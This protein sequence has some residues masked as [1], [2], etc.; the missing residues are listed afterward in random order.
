[1]N[2]KYVTSEMGFEG[3][4][5]KEYPHMRVFETQI[6]FLDA[7][8]IPLSNILQSNKVYSGDL[9]WNIG[10]GGFDKPYISFV[11][12]NFH[13]TVD[14]LKERFD[15]VYI[16]QDGE[17]GWWNQVDMKLQVWW[18]N[19]LNTADK[20][21]VP[22]ET[23]VNFYR[24]LFPN[25]RLGV[26]RSVM[27]DEGLDKS[28]FLNKEDRAILVGPCTYEYNGFPQVLLAQK[29]A[30][31]IDIP[32]MG[33]DRMPDDSWDMASNIGVNYLKH[34]TW[35]DWMYNLSRYSYGFMLM[36]ATAAG[37]FALNCA[38]HGIPCIGDKK[39][40]TQRILFPDL[41]V[42]TYEIG[43]ASILLDKLRTDK[44]FYIDIAQK[45][46]EIYNSEF[47]KEKYL[48]ILEKDF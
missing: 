21:F 41:S 4:F 22:N 30:M 1:M 34:M 39:A 6:Y 24:G 17:I 43:T 25:T 2:I 18:Y 8:H 38:Y 31:P 32:P 20:I 7:Q 15:N 36:N 33:E 19:Q 27:T 9:W 47:S 5:S 37:S 48:E 23:D 29:L 3:K 28:K 14:L 40:D 11:Y 42:D 44:S 26:M 46:R 10:K 16:Y 45:A 13:N 35:T 12:N